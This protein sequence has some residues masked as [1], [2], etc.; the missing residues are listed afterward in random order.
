MS[1]LPTDVVNRIMRFVSQPTT[2]KI[3]QLIVK[4]KISNFIGLRSNIDRLFNDFEGDY[5]DYE[6]H[7]ASYPKP[8]QCKI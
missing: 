3:K 6:T 5:D 4:T 8:L 2:D 1:N 7:V